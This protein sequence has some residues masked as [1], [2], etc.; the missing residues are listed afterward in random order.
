MRP[1]VDVRDKMIE[2]LDRKVLKGFGY[3]DRLYRERLTERVYESDVETRRKK[4]RSCTK[5]LD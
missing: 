5:W 3:V 1:K 4:C 2:S